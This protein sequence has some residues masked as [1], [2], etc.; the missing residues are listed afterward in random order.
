MDEFKKKNIKSNSKQIKNPESMS[1]QKRGNRF[2]TSSPIPR[3]N[4]HSQED[5]ILI[6]L[7]LSPEYK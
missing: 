3:K 1:P 6:S 7:S 2:A 4:S 5:E